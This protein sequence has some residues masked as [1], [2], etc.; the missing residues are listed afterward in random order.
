[1]FALNRPRAK[2]IRAT[3]PWPRVIICHVTSL[4]GAST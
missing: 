3:P 4:L 1:M 2:S